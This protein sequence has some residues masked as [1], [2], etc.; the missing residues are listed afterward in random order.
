LGPSAADIRDLQRAK[1]ILEQ[2]GLAAQISSLIGRPVETAIKNLPSPF[3][4]AIVGG[5]R[6]ALRFGLTSMVDTLDH[7]PGLPTSTMRYRIAGGLTGAASGFFGVAALPIELPVSTLLILRSIAE[8]AR[9]QGEDLARVETQ[10]ACLEVLALGSDASDADDASET[11]Y[12]ATRIGLAQSIGAAAQY[13]GR[14]GLVRKLAGPVSELIARI[15]ARFSVRI[16]Q[17]M[18][19]KAIPMLGAASGAALN[20]LFMSHFQD[21]AWAHFTVRRL[22]RAHGLRLIQQRYEALP[23]DA[24]STDDVARPG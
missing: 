20:A 18:A 17:N 15:A 8:I 5:T 3:Q 24:S 4:R 9:N 2:P 16:T 23:A 13:L 10:L 6:H 21:L 11:G 12:Y 22:E 14:R 7:E 19:A 1:Q